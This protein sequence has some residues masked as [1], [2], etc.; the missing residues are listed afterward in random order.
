MN[1]WYV[2]TN[3]QGEDGGSFWVEADDMSMTSE[4]DISFLEKPKNKESVVL[5]IIHRDL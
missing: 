1:R 4:G 5:C 3:D 2:V